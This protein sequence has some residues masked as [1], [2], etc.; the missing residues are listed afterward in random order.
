[1]R[2]LRPLRRLASIFVRAK[3]PL[4]AVGAD[5]TEGA[6]SVLVFADIVSSTSKAAA[7]GNLRWRSLLDEH[8]ERTRAVLRR[9]G[10][11][12]V[13]APGD[14]LFASFGSASAAVG[15]A[16]TLRETAAELGLTLRVGV[17]AG[18]CPTLD[19]KPCGLPVHVAARVAAAADPGS[20]LVT[21]TVRDLVIGWPI[22]FVD[23]GER[24]L[25]EVPG[26]WHL[27]EVRDAVL[28]A[29]A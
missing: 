3:T 21:G 9:F 17:H 23:R 13:D 16:C 5:L 24:T 27:Y 1:V 29:A 26:R 28:I 14:G 10:G 8:R 19:G 4:P 2:S 6:V 15:F 25:R 7:I 20:V 18:E 12:E 22:A 11:A